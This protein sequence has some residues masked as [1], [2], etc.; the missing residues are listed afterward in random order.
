MTQAM[1]ALA[2][3]NRVRFARIE[4]KKAVKAR[5]VLACELLLS[6]I[7]PWLERM[8]FEDLARVIPHYPSREYRRLMAVSRTN[9]TAEVGGL[10]E[11]KRGE[12]A[13]LLAEWECRPQRIGR[14][15]SHPAHS[16]QAHRRAA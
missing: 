2:E 11:R 5:E 13:E 9:Y 1:K 6:D 14:A 4:L 15:R 16:G 3:A 8:R 12:L 7:P 10:T